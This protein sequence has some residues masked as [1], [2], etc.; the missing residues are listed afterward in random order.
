MRF[1]KSQNTFHHK[2]H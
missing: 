2:H 1:V